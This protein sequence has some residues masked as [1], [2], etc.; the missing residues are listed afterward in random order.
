MRGECSVARKTRIRLHAAG[1]PNHV[2]RTSTIPA[3]RFDAPEF[4]SRW[5]CSSPSGSSAARAARGTAASQDGR[6]A[7]LLLNLPE[8]GREPGKQVPDGAIPGRISPS[9]RIFVGKVLS[10]QWGTGNV[11]G[12]GA[13]G[14][15]GSRVRAGVPGRPGRAA[16]HRHGVQAAVAL[17]QRRDAG[18]ERLQQR[19][20][21]CPPGRP[22]AVLPRRIREDRVRQ[23]G[24]PR[25][26]AGRRAGLLPEGDEPV[27]AETEQAVALDSLA[28]GE[29]FAA[30][31]ALL[32][33]GRLTS[34]IVGPY[35]V[36]QI[37]ALRA[38]DG[39]TAA[40]TLAE[41]LCDATNSVELRAE[42]PPLLAELAQEALS[43]SPAGSRTRT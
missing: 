31:A 42:G 18:D 33:R 5:R 12:M 3:V 16:S 6:R 26:N 22:V 23:S 36:S 37:F 27:I 30:L 25:R 38:L 40:R 11:S 34:A 43:R 19:R 20:R 17:L 9:E 35:A 14:T 39:P 24:N 28:P 1:A 15:G 32:K 2:H 7:D 13:P 8:P 10:I 29:R 21:G 41:V 4:F